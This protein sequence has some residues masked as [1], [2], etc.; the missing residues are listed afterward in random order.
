MVND[1]VSGEGGR[2]SAEEN[3]DGVADGHAKMTVVW[4]K[5]ERKKWV[6]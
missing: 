1:G 4:L 2:Q 3:K 6:A 5:A